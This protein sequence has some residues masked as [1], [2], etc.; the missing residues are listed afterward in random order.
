MV[1]EPP[2]SGTGVDRRGGTST[3][4]EQSDSIDSKLIVFA[5][6]HDGSGGIQLTGG[7]SN[8]P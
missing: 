7:R 5:V 6:T 1:T 3:Y 2:D 4:S 8:G